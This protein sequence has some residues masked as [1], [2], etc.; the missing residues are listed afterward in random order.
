MKNAALCLNLLLVGV[1][2]APL[3]VECGNVLHVPVW[4]TH[5]MAEKNCTFTHMFYADNQCEL[6]LFFNGKFPSYMQIVGLGLDANLDPDT[7]EFGAAI[8]RCGVMEFAGIC[9]EQLLHVLSNLR[10]ACGV[11]NLRF[12]PTL[13]LTQQQWMDRESPKVYQTVRMPTQAID[14][15]AEAK[16]VSRSLR[17]LEETSEAGAAPQQA[18][19][20]E[21]T[22][23]DERTAFVDDY[24]LDAYDYET[25]AG[26]YF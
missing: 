23:D 4:F 16:L 19:D 22:G 12:V 1:T 3:S 11:D 15:Q 6:K 20:G 25:S 8:C 2:L 10:E 18:N 5:L 21:V 24:D 26:L 17:I 7:A 13:G 14:V 9:S